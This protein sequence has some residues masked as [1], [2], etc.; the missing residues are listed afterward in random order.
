MFSS[1]IR[2]RHVWSLCQSVAALQQGKCRCVVFALL[3]IAGHKVARLFDPLAINGPLHWSM[4][5]KLC[6]GYKICLV[7]PLLLIMSTNDRCFIIA[8]HFLHLLRIGQQRTW[9]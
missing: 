3:V 4:V 8:S 5:L 6:S 7:L 9:S 1:R 2:K